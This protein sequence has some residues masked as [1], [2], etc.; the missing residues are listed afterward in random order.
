MALP[1][2]NLCGKEPLQ[3]R[4]FL[5][6][7]ERFIQKVLRNGVP[8]AYYSRMIIIESLIMTEANRHS[9]LGE[10]ASVPQLT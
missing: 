8:F 5:S 10:K 1:R 7:L 9:F 6:Y 2:L 3:E 4:E